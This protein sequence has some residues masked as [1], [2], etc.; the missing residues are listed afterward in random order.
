M[1]QYAYN[2][3]TMGTEAGGWLSSRLSSDI[4]LSQ[5]KIYDKKIKIKRKN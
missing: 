3:N 5:N 4:K 2:F 1:V